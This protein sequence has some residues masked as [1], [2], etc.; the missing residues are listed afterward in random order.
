[1]KNLKP[2]FIIAIFSLIISS[3]TPQA[4]E[5]PANSIDNTQATGSEGE[6]TNNGT[7]D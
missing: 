1:M 5:K 3:C 7:K 4:I 2:L 6:S